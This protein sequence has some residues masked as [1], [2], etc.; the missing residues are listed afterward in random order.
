M[1]SENG[2]IHGL[3][4]TLIVLVTTMSCGTAGPGAA[5]GPLA[6]FFPIL[7]LLVLLFFS[8]RAAIKSL[9]GDTQSTGTRLAA[10]IPSLIVVLI[11]LYLIVRSGQERG[12]APAYVLPIV[13]PLLF[14]GIGLL[15]ILWFNIT[16]RK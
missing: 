1:S 7:V 11:C 8:V 10:S 16:L 6:N 15:C 5:P 3:I 9:R 2:V 14:L 4:G 13:V 12:E